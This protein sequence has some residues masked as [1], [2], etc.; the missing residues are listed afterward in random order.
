[1]SRYQC[2]AYVCLWQHNFYIELCVGGANVLTDVDNNE[3][4][5]GLSGS[6]RH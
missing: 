6:H 2:E 4:R 5:H 1:M 3:Q